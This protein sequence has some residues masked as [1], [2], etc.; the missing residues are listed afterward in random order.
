M[1]A[2]TLPYLAKP[3]L[4]GFNKNYIIKKHILFE[5]N[6]KLAEVNP[7]AHFNT[8]W[9]NNQLELEIPNLPKIYDN[10]G[11]VFT[12]PIYNLISKYDAILTNP[13]KP[14]A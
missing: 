5:Y 6:L 11:E 8:K 7:M 4:S 13:G 14:I 1:E 3:Y 10:S 2:I 9:H 12:T